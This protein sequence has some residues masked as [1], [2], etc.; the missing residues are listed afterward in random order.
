MTL[1]DYEAWPSRAAVPWGSGAE[2]GDSPYDQIDFHVDL[3]CGTRPKARIGVDRYAAPGVAVIA[4]LDTRSGPLTYATAVSP[5]GDAPPL[6]EIPRGGVHHI[7]R[8]GLPFYTSSVKSIISHHFFEHVGAG[9]VT[10]VDECWRVL[11]PGGILRAITP[12]FPST[13]AVEDPDHRRYFMGHED[14]TGTWDAFCVPLGASDLV[15]ADFSVPY[16]GARFEKV[17]QNITPPTQAAHQWSRADRR[18][19]RVALKAVKEMA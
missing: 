19:I 3:G 8:Y 15:L 14:G 5:G 12:L 13:S 16:T 9:F 17:D 6:A 4:E 18:E 10:L 1:F 7:H 2:R 11:E